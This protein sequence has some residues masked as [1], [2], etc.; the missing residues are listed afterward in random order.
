MTSDLKLHVHQ[1]GNG[2]PLLLIHG[3]PFSGQM[4]AR[5][6]GSLS[7]KH[8]VLAPDLPGFGKSAASA[9]EHSVD[10]YARACAAA[11]DAAGISGP[12]ALGGLSMGGYIAL[13]F[14]RLFPERLSALLL[15]STRAGADSAEG[16]ANR[17]KTIASVKEQGASVVTEGMYPKLLAPANYE[18]KP[19]AASELQEIM[20][21][22]TPEGVIAALEVM[23]DRPDSTPSLGAIK[24]PTL[25]VHGKDDQVIP[26]SEAEA[27]AKAIPNSKLAL[28]DGAGHMPNL[29]QQAKFDEAVS[30]FLAAL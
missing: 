12:V 13:A 18:T 26:F 8:Q 2:T 6:L 17:D 3:F 5:Q 4:W 7:S 9:G 25:I 22:A 27:M 16:K 28:I 11:S 30:G 14:A 29:E 24:A 20:K 21:G 19:D 1:A 10:A 15:L 23:R